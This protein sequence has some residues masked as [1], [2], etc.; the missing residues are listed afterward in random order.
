MQTHL[1][2]PDRLEIRHRPLFWAVIFGCI[3]FVLA[4]WGFAGLVEGDW[5]GALIALG[6]GLVM[7]WVVF[8]KIL[9]SFS[10][11]LDR[12]GD[13]VSYKDTRGEKVEGRLSRLTSVACETRFRDDNG[14]AERALVL[15]FTKGDDP[16]RI[17][18]AAFRLRTEDVLHAEH[19][20]SHWLAQTPTGASG[21]DKEEVTVPAPRL[22]WVALIFCALLILA[23]FGAI[24]SGEVLRAA[25]LIVVGAGAGYVWLKRVLVRLDLVLDPA[26]GVVTMTRR[27]LLGSRIWHLPLRHLDGAEVIAVA[28]LR[29]ARAFQR[30][31]AN[32]DLLF[33]NT[34]PNMTIPLSPFGMPEAEAERVAARINDWLRDQERAD[35]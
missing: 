4:V 35:P 30:H 27:T 7:G 1:D 31:S 16:P 25:V 2:T 14:E 33:R 3:L 22:A 15:H 26:G 11:I 29:M 28:R 20:I 9:L 12:G 21:G 17:R 23:G 19:E 6:L 13:L 5:I 18:L 34:R 32:V 24:A 8:R 10:L